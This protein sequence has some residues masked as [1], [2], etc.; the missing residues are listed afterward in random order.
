[1]SHPGTLWVGLAVASS[2]LFRLFAAAAADSVRFPFMRRMPVIRP[3]FPPDIQFVD[4]KA[5]LCQLQ[6]YF[7]GELSIVAPAVGHKLPVGRQ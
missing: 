5:S 2:R 6:S 7:G 1:M 4:E 3:L